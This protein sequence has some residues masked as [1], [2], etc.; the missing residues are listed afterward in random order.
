MCKIKF[1]IAKEVQIHMGMAKCNSI[2]S[3]WLMQPEVAHKCQ[4]KFHGPS[5]MYPKQEL[6]FGKSRRGVLTPKFGCVLPNVAR[7]CGFWHSRCP[8]SVAHQDCSP[9]MAN[10]K[11]DQR[12]L[13]FSS[14]IINIT[15][16]LY[17]GSL[18]L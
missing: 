11:D 12:F 4:Y 8:H 10:V 15:H 18:D 5:P 6:L 9:G 17:K 16:A 7:G 13:E 14:G 2:D 3:S 1:M